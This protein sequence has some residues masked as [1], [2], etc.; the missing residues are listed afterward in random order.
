MNQKTNT[1][2]KN[3]ICSLLLTL[4][5]AALS[6]FGCAAASYCETGRGRT[7]SCREASD[8]SIRAAYHAQTTLPAA[9]SEQKLLQNR[10]NGELSISKTGKRASYALSFIVYCFLTMQL[11]FLYVFTPHLFSKSDRL[12]RYSIVSYLHR[13]DGE[14]PVFN[15]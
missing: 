8:P 10:A 9:I 14:K 1:T 12:P 11:H 15:F 4:F 3:R 7:V 13:S 2:C 5:L 6:L